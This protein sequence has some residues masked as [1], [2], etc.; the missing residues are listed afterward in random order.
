MISDADNEQ[1]E[2]FNDLERGE[3]DPYCQQD[4]PNFR[5]NGRAEILLDSNKFVGVGRGAA[6]GS[7]NQGELR[8]FVEGGW[9]QLAIVSEPKSESGNEKERRPP[10]RFIED[11]IDKKGGVAV[12][13]RVRTKRSDG[14]GCG[15]DEDGT[16]VFVSAVNG[17]SE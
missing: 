12:E 15:F 14:E 1:N 16:G 17:R 11:A 10:E 2:G 13:L 4:A 9:D 6:D 7:T 3:F 5:G 8:N